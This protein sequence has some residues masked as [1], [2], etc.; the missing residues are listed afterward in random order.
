MNK[1]LPRAQIE[2]CFIRAT[3]GDTGAGTLCRGEYME[4]LLRLCNSA[5]PK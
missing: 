2:N 5:H 4:L 3:R 1:R